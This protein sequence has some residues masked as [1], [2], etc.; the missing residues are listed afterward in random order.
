M[1]GKYLNLT[2]L[3]A[4]AAVCCGICLASQADPPS[5]H[6]VVKR[7]FNPINVDGKLDDDD[8]KNCQPI[9]LGGY[10]AGKTVKQPTTAWLL[11]DERYL[12]IAFDCR[13]S[14]IWSTL[15]ERD[16]TLYE[17]E[18]VE[19]F[20]NPDSDRETYVEIE[21]N[22]LGTLWDGFILNRP[23]SRAGILAWNS[24][25]LKRAVRLDGT[26]NDAANTDKGWSVEIAVPFK[27]LVTAANVPP[28]PGDKW[29]V[30]LYRID[31]PKHDKALG[32]YSAWSPVSGETYHDPDRF[33]EIE[34]S[35]EKVR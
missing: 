4:T 33:G 31:L 7:A 25:D 2:L 6:Y 12:Y 30:N 1:P 9:E 24:F 8:W 27:D 26:V 17:Q 5:K 28:R 19:V 11:W 21:V 13:D 15:T 10:N 16:D 20:L 18:V 34:F 14:D 3:C 35:R 22:P 32:D 23:E 29:R